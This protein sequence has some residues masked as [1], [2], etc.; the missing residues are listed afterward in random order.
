METHAFAFLRSPAGQQQLRQ[1]TAVTIT[2]ENHLQLAMQLRQQVDD[3]AL[4]HALLETAVLRQKAVSKFSRAGQM[5]FT[6]DALEQA[7][8]ELIA[9]YR[10]HRFAQLETGPIADLGCGIGGDSLALC[11]QADVIGIDRD[12]VRLRMAACNVAVYGGNGRFHPLQTDLTQLAPLPVAAFFFDPARRDEFGRRLRSVHDYRPPLSL[13]EQW[14]HRVPHAAIKVSPA[15]NYAEIPPTAETEFVSVA[16]DVKEG[17]LWFGGLQTGVQRRATLLPGGHTLTDND[18]ADP[19]P[20]RPAQQYLYEPDGAII[21]AHLVQA[22]GHQLGAAQI[23]PDIAY[24]TAANYQQTP[25]ARCYQLEDY[26]PF[27]LKRLRHYLRQRGISQV[28]I[29]KRGSPLDPQWLERQ[30]RLGQHPSTSDSPAHRILFLTQVEGEAAV[31]VGTVVEKE[32][33]DD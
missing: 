8:G 4:V 24:L 22:L 7:S 31:L 1:L 10:S 30:L 17:I 33:P 28:T 19:L 14:L 9:R 15:I 25:F 27:Q 2:P 5:Y 6:R 29:K 26:F 11:Q 12:G 16:G 3:P 20:I 23:D 32:K 13:A 21:R 18:T